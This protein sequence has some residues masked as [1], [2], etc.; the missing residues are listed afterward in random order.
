MVVKQMATVKSEGSVISYEEIVRQVRAGQ[1]KPIYYLMGEESYYIDRVCD[2]IVTNALKEEE[3]DFNLTVFYG[4]DTDVATVINTAKRYPMMADRQVVVVR[5]AQGLDN[6]DALAF[7][8]E[9]PQ[10][11]TVLILCHK[12]GVLDRRKK[13]AEVIQ[14]K[15]ILFESKRL[16][17]SQLP[18]FVSSYL[19]RKGIGIEPNAIQLLCDHVGSDLNRLASELDKLALACQNNQGRVS[20]SLIEEQIGISK[21]FNNFE[22]VNALVEKNSYKAFVIVKYFNNNPKSFS[23]QVTLS[24]LFN[25]FS[26]LMLAYYAPQKNEE[27]ISIW[28]GLPKWQVVR[29]IIPAMKNYSG[30]K[31]M[32]IIGE[33]R[34]TDAKSK[35]I[36]CS[37]TSNGEL[38][39]G[40]IYYILH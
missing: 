9:Q 1:F 35:G 3:R 28:T 24:V 10:S 23:L 32:Q 31:V 8:L 19:R 39:R 30:V 26:N 36:E 34:K 7:Y 5:E 21:D 12:H 29:N 38:L 18:G 25:F 13:L 40:L 17:D 27:G 33:L 16:Y 2:Y 22:L 20:A 14:K 4:P 6:K 37:N 15:G 11:T